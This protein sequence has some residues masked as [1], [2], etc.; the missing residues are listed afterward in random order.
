M[1]IIAYMSV[2]FITIGGNEMIRGIS[3]IPCD[4]ITKKNSINWIKHDSSS[5]HV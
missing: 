3:G 2:H 4:Y 5:S 1:D